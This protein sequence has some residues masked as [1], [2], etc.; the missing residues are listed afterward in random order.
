MKTLVTRRSSPHHPPVIRPG[1]G[2]FS[3]ITRVQQPLPSDPIA[4]ARQ[5]WREAGWTEAADGMAVV[6][7]VFRVNQ[8]LLARIEAA[9]KPHGLSFARFEMLRLLGFSRSGRM[10]M[11]R[12]RDLLQVHPASV[13]NTVDRLEAADLVRRT[14]N[15]RD[16]RSFLVEITPA[17]AEVLDRATKALNE[18]VFAAIDFDGT[19][20]Q[21]LTRLLAG[22][23]RRH[24]D[25]RDPVPHPEPF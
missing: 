24:G 6:T 17:G 8:I 14:P 16:G 25:F 7:S 13:T 15:P 12:A 20:L 10:P 5:N 11:S 1:D 2:W 4:Q 23:R 18:Q 19:D 21:T 22:F 3:S 9:L